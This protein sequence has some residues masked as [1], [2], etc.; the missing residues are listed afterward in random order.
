MLFFV[1]MQAR[2]FD[3]N[4]FFN[5]RNILLIFILF[6]LHYLLSDGTLVDFIKQLAG[7]IIIPFLSKFIKNNN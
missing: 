4:R 2:A 6:F 3:F 5:A 7:W 1:V